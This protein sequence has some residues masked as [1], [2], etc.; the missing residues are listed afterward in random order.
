MVQSID[1]VLELLNSL[2]PVPGL[3]VGDTAEPLAHT[4]RPPC[5]LRDLQAFPHVPASLQDFWCRTAGAQLFEDTTYG[6]WGLILHSPSAA[7]DAT[8]DYLAARPSEAR[9]GDL[10]IGA[11]LGDCDLLIVRADPQAVDDGQVMVATPLDDRQDWSLVG[12]DFTTF[13]HQY[14]QARG[15]KFW[16]GSAEAVYRTE[17]QEGAGKDQ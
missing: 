3:G 8:H 14:V 2:E 15:R 9:A 12:K 6:Q 17:A 4:L 13:L 1:V 5:T 11:F 10:V 16:E 7:W